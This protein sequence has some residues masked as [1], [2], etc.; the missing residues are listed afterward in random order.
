[1]NRRRELP[2][3]VGKLTGALMVAVLC[4]FYCPAG[5]CAGL[6]DSGEPDSYI[7][8]PRMFKENQT[9][10]H[11]P[12][13][14]YS[15]LQ[16]ALDGERATSPFY[17]SLDGAWKFH[18]AKSFTEN[19][20]EFYKPGYDA[21][22]W[23]TIDVPSCWQMKGYGRMIY[24]NIGLMESLGASGPPDVPDDYN[25][26]GSYRRTFR[27]PE[28]WTDREIFLHFEGV[29]SASWVW[30][31]GEY[32][33]Y[34]E[35][36]M[37]PA[38]YNITGHVKPGRNTLA[39]RVCRWSD[40]TYLWDCDAVGFSG[41][42]R[43]AYLF[44]APRVHVQ[45]F[46]ARRDLG[47]DY[48]D[49]LLR[50]QAEIRNYSDNDV[51]DHRLRARLFDRKGNP[52]RAAETRNINIKRDNLAAVNLSMRV[53]S[54][55]KW[56]AEHPNLY[57]LVLE[58]ENPAGRVTERL[59]SRV[60]F[61]SIEIKD[62]H[63]TINGEPVVIKGS[64]RFEHSPTGGRT[65][66]REE[67][68][69]DIRLMKRFN[70]NAV[71]SPVHPNDP[72]WYDLTDEYG[73]Y[74]DCEAMLE[75]HANWSLPRKP[76]WKEAV[77]DRFRRTLQRCKNHPSIIFWC[78]G[79]EHGQGEVT[80]RMKEYAAERDSRLMYTQGRGRTAPYAD[81]NG[82]YA[83]S[84]PPQVERAGQKNGK[85]VVMGEY[86]HASGNS[87]GFFP[88]MWDVIEKYPRLQGGFQ[89]DWLDQSVYE[90]RNGKK[91]LD[92]VEYKDGPFS[93][94]GMVF[95]DRNPQPEYYQFKHVLQP[96][97]VEKVNLREGRVRI[98]NE[99][100]FTNLADRL[101]AAWRLK[102]GGN[103]LQS[104][105]LNAAV[106]PNTARA[107]TLPIEKP[108]LEPGAEYWLDIRFTLAG[109]T[110]WADEGYE[111]ARA[112]FKMP[113]DVPGEEPLRLEDMA[114]VSLESDG[115]EAVIRADRVTCNVSRQKGL[116]SITRGGEKVVSP[117]PRLSIWRAPIVNARLWGWTM[118]DAW[119]KAGLH[120]LE[121]SVEHVEWEKLSESTAQVTVDARASAPGYDVAYET[122]CTYTI[123]GSGDILLT[124]HIVPKGQ[125][126][127]CVPRMGLELE[128]P[129]RLDRFAWY[130]RGPH[131]TMP[132]RKSGAPVGR[133]SGSVA[134]QYVPYAV[135]QFNGNKTD[136]RW[137]SISEGENGVG[138]LVAGM[139]P[140]NVSVHRYSYPAVPE[141]KWELT[142]R[143]TVLLN[144]DHKLTGVGDT[145]NGPLPRH[146][147]KPT[148]T[149]YTIRL[150]PLDL[151]T[152]DPM[153]IGRQRLPRPQGSGS[154]GK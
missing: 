115:G 118:V 84:T 17:R 7:E 53:E 113:F 125:Q 77:F 107:Y 152:A 148:E 136:V 129:A 32:V 51:S 106:P 103:V 74:V 116:V 2:T 82:N 65:V 79:N 112:Q 33:G 31:N 90:T 40:A 126:P 19:P 150:R 47:K 153:K 69:R 48:S 20:A 78:T 27:V 61:R 142:E 23:D 137:A 30:I 96:V 127:K 36:G 154:P 105:T 93:I 122:D 10:T 63:I 100:D 104:G 37:L 60:G 149:T 18:W 71:R 29:K 114:S 88:E 75:T 15:S 43:S 102:S 73:L 146:R 130:G 1:M 6:P 123:F 108:E 110:R 70:M 8:N 141:H 131:E 133:Y 62:N 144:I 57:R 44:S 34:N 42:L 139:S 101:D 94:C 4:A 87:L 72:E 98:S 64:F 25:P 89:F 86:G 58:L 56:S 120:K 128:L 147:V 134:D 35:G 117:G 50:V 95:G 45:D 52:V 5:V 46:F 9:P 91:Y 21:S 151:G 14:P 13:V 24:K 59:S 16:Q 28:D 121:R 3:W 26:V 145:P 111:V 12:L 143:D 81:V 67:R 39:V 92:Y 109:N 22:D 135:P 80:R 140:T 99:Y 76:A 138:L 66:S 54:V 132:D 85:P 119:K 124:H 38:E 49:G 97:D 41:I 83:Y 11:V 68:L 55:R